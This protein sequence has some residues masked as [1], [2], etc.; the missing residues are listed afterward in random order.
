MAKKCCS[1]GD[2]SGFLGGVSFQQIDGK[3]YCS[4]CADKYVADAISK[5]LIT[6][7]NNLDGFK[8]KRYLD[9]ESVEIV[10]GTGVFSEIDGEISDFFGVKSTAFEKKLQKAKRTALDRLRYIAFPPRFPENEVPRK[11]TFVRPAGRFSVLD[12]RFLL[13]RNSQ[14]QG[15]KGS[16]TPSMRRHVSCL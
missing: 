4:P 14:V 11:R 13:L 8:V 16:N 1:C 12:R 9:I 3:E 2:E 10:I 15:I 5:I 7:T 6:T